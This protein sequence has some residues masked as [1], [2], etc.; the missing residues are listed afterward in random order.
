MGL[1]M[2]QNSG[3]DC[4]NT[5]CSKCM[6]WGGVFAGALVAL[7]L[8]FLLNAFGVAI[9]ISAFKVSAAGEIILAIGGYIGMVIGVIAVMFIAGWVA[10]SLSHAGCE[11]KCY[12]AL[13]GF[14]SWCIVLVLMV[15]LGANTGQFISSNVKAMTNYHPVIVQMVS[16]TDIAAANNSVSK[17]RITKAIKEEM[18]AD[19]QTIKTLE[20][21]VFLTFALFFISAIASAF[22]GYC[23]VRCKKNGCC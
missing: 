9:G 19:A 17:S 16:E 22:G 2:N 7:G 23:A 14:I 13:Y 5:C 11:S 10:G 20:L 21:A 8:S 3:Q 12:G 6:S 4:K 1:N 18:A 15:M